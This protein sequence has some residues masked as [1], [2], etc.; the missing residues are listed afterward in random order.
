M[1]SAADKFP[2]E[3]KKGP[4]KRTGGQ[5][6]K[7]RACRQ[8]QTVS[9]PK[10]PAAQTETKLEPSVEQSQEEQQIP[11]PAGAQRLQKS[12]EKSQRAPHQ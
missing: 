7:Q 1:K 6:P 9:H 4:Q 12:V 3:G 8:R 5:N 11:Q 10:V 2:K